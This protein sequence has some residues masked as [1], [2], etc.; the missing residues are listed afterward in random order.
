MEDIYIYGYGIVG[1]SRVVRYGCVSCILNKSFIFK[2]VLFI[3]VII[4][5]YIFYD[6]FLLVK[7]FFLIKFECLEN[8][9]NDVNK[10]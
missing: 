1:Y 2:G 4:D 8:F 3:I 9:L 6:S 5:F 10:M 7:F